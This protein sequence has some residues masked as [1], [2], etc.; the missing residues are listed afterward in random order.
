MKTDIRNTV[1]AA[2]LFLLAGMISTPVVLGQTKKQGLQDDVLWY[3]AAAV[4]WTDAIPLGNGRLGAMVFGGIN[5]DRIQF[6][7]ESLWTGEPREYDHPGA[8]VYLPE[9]RRL[10]SEN[11][12]AEAERLADEKFMGLQSKAGNK[13]KWFDD[14]RAGKGI[15]GNPS[16]AVYDDSKW[17]T[18]QVPSYEG[19]EIVGLEGMDGAVWFRTTFVLPANFN[20]S[21]SKK[22]K[23]GSGE[24]ANSK[25][26]WMIDLNRIRNHDFTYING[27]LVGTTEGNEPRKY[28]IPY[29][30]LKPGKNVLSIQVLNYFD[31]GGI[32][33]YK[34]TTKHISVY[35]VNGT[36]A[37]AISLN[38]KWK[39]KVQNDEPPA[40]PHFQADYQ[41]F[42][43]LVLD[44]GNHQTN[45][46][47]NYRRDLSLGTAISTTRYTVG[48]VHYTREYFISQPGQVIVVHLKADQ[49]G[50]I[51]FSATL[52][53]P[54][55]NTH[56]RK[57]DNYTI[58]MGVK[59][60]DGAL[61]GESYLSAKVT[62]GK[63]V[64]EKGK[65]VISGANEVT[66][67]LA[68]GT[69][70]INY[71]EVSGN[72]DLICQRAMSGI[73]NKTYAE[74]KAEHLREYQP[75]YNTFS[76][77]LG[78]KNRQGMTH[79][80]SSTT[81]IGRQ[82]PTD[83]RL[84]DFK[85]GNDPSFAALYLQ[86]GRY[87]LISSSRPGS[88]PANLQGIWNEQL[89]PSWG[90]KYTTNINLQMNYWPSEVLNLSP[91]HEPLFNMA[92]DLAER[93]RQ[94]AKTHYGASGWVLHHNTDIWMATAP[95]NSST[96]GIWVTGAAWLATDLW[97]HYLFS[98]DKHFLATR[99]YPLMKSAATFF[100]D[101][102]VKDPKTGWLISTP[103]NSPENGGLVAGPT[104]DHQIIRTLFKACIEAAEILQVDT[105]FSKVL[106]K[107]YHEIAP[108][109]IGKYQQLQEWLEDKDDPENKH[110]HVSHLWGVHPGNDI[111]WE[112]QPEFMKAA[113]QSLIYRGDEG[114]GWSLAWK[115]NFWA[116]FKEGDHAMKMIKMLLSPVGESG[117]SY[118]NLFDAHPPFQIDGNFGGAA[119]IA[120][121][122]LQSHTRY[123]D[124]LPALPADFS[125]GEVDGICARGG[126][127]IRMKW[128]NTELKSLQVISKAGNNCHLRYKGMEKNI[129]TKAGGVYTFDKE[130]N[131]QQTK[132]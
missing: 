17:K 88:K 114:T 94:T 59:V 34:D 80:D 115:I 44:F 81:L 23:P 116:R 38:G 78:N 127:V 49:P 41:P 89:S 131:I 105:A 51:N 62:K 55:K 26:D 76:I 77:R 107:K 12:Q 75:Y 132:I 15:T 18:I 83:K 123:I 35:P 13:K 91:M 1:L 125:S 67:Y 46:E 58:A 60:R 64:L 120:E 36:P 110:R 73:N 86:Y 54:H 96:H 82:K 52:K 66:L 50:K 29:Q 109:Q 56:F 68:A 63:V 113:R 69:N 121:M 4:K 22:E 19:W 14:M 20:S 40:V 42:G 95:I 57:I 5:R 130:L 93:G 79:P 108:N 72:P 126:F 21:S 106:Q 39:Y 32:A 24:I 100:N 71:K 2:G 122:L 9:I 98:Q 53:S 119:G 48:D 11:K 6:N 37:K 97:E 90:S 30:F 84:E 31:K 85:N 25:A 128:E 8:A 74:V 3:T 118:A 7:E 112:D 99:A 70:F 92:D 47:Q 129:P 10:L 61:K 104:M 28:G 16:L 103:S 43:D 65:I 33:G 111:T 101:F 27:H 102:L 124:L 117:G 87:L 45:K